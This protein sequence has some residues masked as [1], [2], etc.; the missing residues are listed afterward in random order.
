MSETLPEKGCH[1][2][3]LKGTKKCIHPTGFA[4]RKVAELND[5][6]MLPIDTCSKW[7]RKDE[8]GVPKM[9]D[10]KTIQEALE[11]LNEYMSLDST[12]YIDLLGKIKDKLASVA[13]EMAEK[14]AKE[15]KK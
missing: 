12:G 2:C 14:D 5:K 15:E 4:F 6:L 9:T 10:A 11:Q 8:Q 1:N 3:N 13:E 7:R